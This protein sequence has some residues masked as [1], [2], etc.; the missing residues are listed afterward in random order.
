MVEVAHHES[1]QH[2]CLLHAPE[3]G[4]TKVEAFGGTNRLYHLFGLEY[5]ARQRILHF[6]R[7]VDLPVGLQTPH[8]IDLP[9]HPW[10]LRHLFELGGGARLALSRLVLLKI[11]HGIKDVVLRYR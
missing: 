10:Y 4:H 3:S 9:G 8:F 11:K 1:V 7:L 2:A 5:H 6:L